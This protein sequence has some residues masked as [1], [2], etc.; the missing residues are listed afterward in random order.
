MATLVPDAIHRAALA[1]W[2]N[3]IREGGPDYGPPLTD[4]LSEE[5]EQAQR[6]RTPRLI[7]PTGDQTATAERPPLRIGR[8][9]AIPLSK[10]AVGAVASPA[11]FGP[12]SAPFVV[13]TVS[14]S[15]NIARTAPSDGLVISAM[16]FD[17]PVSDLEGNLIGAI[18]I[19]GGAIDAAGTQFYAPGPS[20]QTAY[21]TPNIIV[22]YP[23]WF[24]R[25]CGKDTAAGGKQFGV[26]VQIGLLSPD[27][28]ALSFVPTITPEVIYQRTARAAPLPRPREA[29]YPRAVRILVTAG[30][31][32]AAARII[33]FSSLAPG[34]RELGTD[35][36]TGRF[37]GARG[38][39][40]IW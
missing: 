32:G 13:Q 37:V 33:P 1:V 5:N 20:G 27:D 15:T 4:R 26:L 21:L 23:N 34:L 22:P 8:I 36:I 40:P 28:L 18:T 17:Q 35:P 16:P 7:G 38:I 2:K 3:L 12:I 11:T 9:L 14:I 10:D 31:Y 6:L 25:A 24:L 29:L 30:T 39:E 19:L